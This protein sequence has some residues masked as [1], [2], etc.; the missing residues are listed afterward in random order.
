MS[1]TRLAGWVG[2][3]HH[4]LDNEGVVKTCK[5]ISRG[6][7]IAAAAGADLWTAMCF[8]LGEWRGEMTISWVKSCKEDGGA[9]TNEHEQQN[10]RADDDAEKA[11]AHSDSFLYRAGYCS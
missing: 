3:T 7:K 2:E 1:T 4:R 11:Y 6:F 5:H 8:Y 10:K 9:K